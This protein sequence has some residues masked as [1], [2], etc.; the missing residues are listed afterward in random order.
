[1]RQLLKTAVPILMCSVVLG[2]GPAAAGEY[3]VRVCGAAL[4]EG[5]RSDALTLSRSDRNMRVER[6]CQPYGRGDGG[7]ITRNRIYR[8][9]TRYKS[10]AYAI[11]DAPPGTVIKRLVWSGRYQRVDCDWSV[12]LVALGSGFRRVL[13]GVRAGE[14]CPRR[15][16]VAEVARYRAPVPLPVE[17]ATRI[18]QQVVCGDPKGCATSRT[19]IGA[20][21]DFRTFYARIDL[22]DVQGPQ[23]SV[24]PTGL[25]G[26]S[27]V[28]GLQ[29]VELTSTDNVGI[30]W[31]RISAGS[32]E[33]AL[34]KRPCVY[35]QRIPC[36]NGSAQLQ[37]QTSRVGDGTQNFTV[38]VADGAQNVTSVQ[39]P[40]KID[41][42]PPGRVVPAVEGGDGWRRQPG[43]AIG[44]P[45][46]PETDRAPI[47][48]AIYRVRR[49]GTQPWG[50]KQTRAEG[51]LTR[52]AGL[53]VPPGDWEL[54][55]WRTDA[56]GNESEN[57]ASDPVHLRY[58]PEPPELSF[59]R[60]DAADPARVA[61][62]VTD[63]VSGVANG[64]IEL[65]REG[66]AA[67]RTVA[68]QLEGSRLVARVDDGNL[69]AGL[70]AL[71]ARAGD[72]AGNQGITDRL[73][74]GFPAVIR[75][76][77]R[78]VSTLT[79]GIVG[80][81]T[82]RRRVGR[83]GRRRVVRRR[84]TRLFP[85]ARVHQRRRAVI[86]GRLIGPGGTP[87]SG[88]DLRVLAGA[89]GGPEAE[90]ARMRTDAHGGFR[91]ALT[92]GHTQVLRVVFD[93]TTT[94]LPAQQQISLLVPATSSLRASRRR[95]RNGS[96]VVFS[97]R[98]GTV[99]L[100]AT[101]KLVELQAHFRGRWRT[102]QTLRTD[103]LGRWRF[104]YRFGATV[105]RVRYGFRARL[106]EEAG[107]PY[108]AGVSRRVAVTVLGR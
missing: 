101:G 26:G 35:A 103:P 99:P 74:D 63:R 1:M 8:G 82:V 30:A 55:L 11:F 50:E 51:G 33:L 9:K 41:N 58:D 107:Y 85:R 48:G 39:L 28:R 36:P 32:G 4:Q 61:V 65:R 21:A 72:Q 38:E 29:P 73:A 47:T 68:T 92:A 5:L 89:P 100:P 25:F 95:L 96:S 86:A 84:V 62:G 27:W 17:G 3:P 49:A 34:T 10:I 77:A 37:V 40:A 20:R 43:F 45:D 6:D 57:L 102:F 69:P 16:G 91:Q 71:R 22:T 81:R 70:Y 66:E 52:L 79:A 56:A 64:E 98:V 53:D 31:D 78:S 83:G 44:W 18:V 94:S 59:E 42:T 15:V 19:R 60:Q 46:A 90:I 87:R 105:G 24:A 97:G 67:W 12:Q 104:R 54:I 108:E 13:K 88:V 2:A 93:G 106:P 76:P 23:V 75:L 80:Q 14:R 7:V